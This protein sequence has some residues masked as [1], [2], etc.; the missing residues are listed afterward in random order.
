MLH[1][2]PV[3]LG[4]KVVAQGSRSKGLL[5]TIWPAVTTV[6]STVCPTK[7]HWPKLDSKIKSVVQFSTK[8]LIKKRERGGGLFYLLGWNKILRRLI[9]LRVETW[10][11]S[12]HIF[13]SFLVWHTLESKPVQVCVTVRVCVCCELCLKKVMITIVFINQYYCNHKPWFEM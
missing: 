9:S 2:L 5:G 11:S 10:V 1:V 4:I 12:I 7:H 8:C 13:F 3:V 6:F